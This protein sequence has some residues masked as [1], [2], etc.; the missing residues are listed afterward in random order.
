MNEKVI[1][2]E[3]IIKKI[4]SC[5]NWDEPHNNEFY[6][7]VEVKKKEGINP[8]LLSYPNYIYELISPYIKQN[9]P[10]NT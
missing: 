2:L 8:S 6:K 5:Y 3:D 1:L 10:P 9:L 7:W 4:Y